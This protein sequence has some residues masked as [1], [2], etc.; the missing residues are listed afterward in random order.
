M[1]EQRVR[2]ELPGAPASVREARTLVR[3]A[4]HDWH[5]DLLEDDVTLMVS[6]LA[7]NAVLHAGSGFAVEVVLTRDTL[8][9][10]VS[11]HSPARPAVRHQDLSA[12][13]GRGMSMIATLSTAWGT[14]AGDGPYTKSVWFEV[15]LAAAWCAG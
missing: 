8:R 14:L 9:V 1:I 13:T 10:T 7:T 3:G 12:G 6:E 2:A 15:P 11:D 4:L 5:L